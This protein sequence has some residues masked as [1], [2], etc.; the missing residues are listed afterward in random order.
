MG[1]PV[2]GWSTTVRWHSA[3]GHTMDA[4]WSELL[5]IGLLLAVVVLSGKV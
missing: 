5:L 3:P 1:A 4:T 2:P